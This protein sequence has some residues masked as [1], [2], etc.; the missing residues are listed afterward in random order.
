MW[1]GHRPLSTPRGRRWLSRPGR[2]TPSAARATSLCP[3][4]CPGT[5]SSATSGPGIIIIMENCYKRYNRLLESIY[6]CYC[7]QF[8]ISKTF[9]ETRERVINVPRVETSLSMKL[10]QNMKL[11][12]K[13]HT[14]EHYKCYVCL[15]VDA[16]RITLESFAKTQKLNCAK[17]IKCKFRHGGPGQ[18][19]RHLVI[20]NCHLPPKHPDPPPL[21]RI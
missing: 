14:L 9:C 21:L 19:R 3:G 17:N 20:T 16:L 11:H 7:V 5:P 12:W 15:I 8:A 6:D 18:G 2:T 13:V 10:H 1:S 4:T